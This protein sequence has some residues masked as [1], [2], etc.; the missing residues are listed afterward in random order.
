MES[1][2]KTRDQLS[3][4][5]RMLRQRLAVLEIADR[6]RQQVETELRA[7]EDRYRFVVEHQTELICRFRP[8]TTLTFVN[9]AYCR[10]FG[11]TPQELIGLSYFRLIPESAREEARV[12]LASMMT[13]PRSV[14]IEQ[15]ALL[16]TG[17]MAWQQWVT[18][19]IVDA[20]GQVQEFLAVG[21]DITE[22]KQAVTALQESETHYRTLVEGSIQAISIVDQN[23]IRLFANTAFAKMFGYADPQELI[24]K[25]TAECVAPHERER[26]YGYWQ[27]Y[28]GETSPMRIEYQGIRKDGTFIWLE[29]L[30]SFVTWEGKRVRLLT[31]VDIT[32]RK[33]AEQERLKIERQ[34][35]Q[36]QKLESLGLLAGGIAHDFNNLLTGI[37]AN[38]GMAQRQLGT[39]HPVQP[40][41]RE[42]VQGA[43]LASHLTGQLLAYAGKGRFHIQPVNL[44]TEVRKIEA[45]LHI[46]V[47]GKAHLVFDLASDLPAIEGDLTQMHQVL[48]NL[49][50]N[51][52]ECTE[53]NVTIGIK[54]ALVDLDTEG[55]R[56][57]LPGHGMR[58]GRYVMLE[59]QDNGCGMDEA[60]R[61][62]IF[63]PFFTTKTTGRG[64]GLAATLGIVHGHG[65]GLQ[66]ESMPN[67]GTT[68]KVFFPASTQTIEA[69]PEEPLRDLSGRKVVLIVDDDAYVLQAATV[70][71]QSFGYRVIVADDGYK[72]VDTFRSRHAEIDLV[73]LDM[74]MP[75]MSGEDTLRALR[76]ICPEVKVL[77]SSAYNENEVSQ[78]VVASASVDFLQKPYDPDQLAI[79][80]KQLLENDATPLPSLNPD[81]ALH[82]LRTTYRQKLPERLQALAE[83]I[84]VVQTHSG[85]EDALQQAFRLAHTLKGTVGSYGF[86][87]LATTL[88]S[89]EDTLK[90]IQEGRVNS[91]EATWARL[92]DALSQSQASLK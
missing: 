72:A 71:L 43:K 83:A 42:V 30:S 74:T 78:Q 24:G 84:R 57:L 61:Q 68:F 35:Q 50:I 77:L 88:E 86:D 25:S 31:M 81:Q 16:P 82:A 47:Q 48:L 29:S 46:A 8:D 56:Q 79:K 66:L 27:Q 91:T 2:P 22:L 36:A 6:K 23:R 21:R 13:Q 85:S 17:E 52:A 11:K 9:D 92:Q 73:I 18:H 59:V 64:L 7:S 5:N 60:T 1:N 20:Q 89:I 53:D 58:Q 41:V 4:E 45:L 69:V 44:S 67:V 34:M 14:K 12:C 3:E 33:R 80:V 54:T 87:D 40:Y 90:L 19:A 75:G 65:G 63:D 76:D 32:E 62:R 70:T 39:D 38:A 26:M 28:Q 49:A 55:L 10:Y 51:A 37:L 15:P